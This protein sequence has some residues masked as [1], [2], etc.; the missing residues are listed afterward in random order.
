MHGGTKQISEVAHQI[1]ADCLLFVGANQ[2]SIHA[3]RHGNIEMIEPE[4]SHDFL[5]LPGTFHRAYKSRLDHALLK[6]IF[7]WTATTLLSLW[8]FITTR[9]E[10]LNLQLRQRCH[11]GLVHLSRLLPLLL[12][13]SLH[14]LLS[15]LLPAVLTFLSRLQFANLVKKDKHQ[16]R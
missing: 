10:F 7:K 1:R 8:Q 16:I 3:F 15:R 5:Q 6:A 14:R 12:S 9:T 2:D 13:R 11:R 4:V